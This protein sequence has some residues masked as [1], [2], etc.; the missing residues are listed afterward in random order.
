MTVDNVGGLLCSVGEASG[1][2]LHSVLTDACAGLKDVTVRRDPDR[3]DTE[4][5]Q[6]D[7]RCFTA[8]VASFVR[9][10]KTIHL[11]GLHYAVVSAGDIVKPDGKPYYN[12]DRQWFE[13]AAQFARWP[14]CLPFD[15]IA[16]AEDVES[17]VR[18]LFAGSPTQP[19]VWRHASGTHSVRAGRGWQSASCAG[20]NGG[21][22]RRTS[23]T[24]K[25]KRGKTRRDPKRPLQTADVSTKPAAAPIAQKGPKDEL[26]KLK[27]AVG[28]SQRSS[29]ALRRPISQLRTI[30][31]TAEILNTSPRTVRRIIDSGALPVHRFGRLVRI[32]DDDIAVLLAASRNA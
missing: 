19:F 27:S 9:V 3:R 8:P 14:G 29:R 20:R 5:G 11:T 17:I 21:R 13:E 26:P 25:H 10:W 2:R 4:A 28:G 22:N 32:S 31:E 7:G 24:E 18:P 30:D 12:E 16:D 6:R 15:R 23:P 1:G